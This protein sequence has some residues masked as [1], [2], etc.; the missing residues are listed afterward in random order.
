VRER[1]AKHREKPACASCHDRI[2]PPGFALEN[3]DAVGRW[4]EL[5]AERP[6]DASGG[7]PDG[8]VFD[9]AAGLEA[10][11]L[12]RPE[13]FVAAF[14]ERLLTFAL[15]RAVEHHDGPALRAIVRETR[16]GKD[17]FSALVCGIVKSAPFRMRRTP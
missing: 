10:A 9:G 3:F 6:L 16:E 11:L 12:R 5:E 4:R 1:L 15:G 7:L 14:A 2:D 8:S 13:A 17:R